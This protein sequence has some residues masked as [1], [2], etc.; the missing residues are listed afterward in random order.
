MARSDFR[1]SYPRR[2]RY[3]EID[4]QMV[5]FNSRYLEYF[6]VGVTEYWRAVGVYQKSLVES[7]PEFHVARATVDFRRAILV[8]EIVDICVRCTRIGRT[9]MSFAFE[10]H[11]AKADD[12]RATGEEVCVHVGHSQGQ[13][14]PVPQWMIDLFEVYE[15]RKLVVPNK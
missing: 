12:L 10:L 14:V 11:G 1:F 2:V 7:G 3:A 8:D 5:M 15:G 9:S 4:G 6:D 13:P